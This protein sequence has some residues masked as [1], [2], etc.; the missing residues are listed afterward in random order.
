MKRVGIV[1]SDLE[2][3]GSGCWTPLQK[4]RNEGDRRGLARCLFNA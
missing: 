1:G 2:S 4:V 3:S